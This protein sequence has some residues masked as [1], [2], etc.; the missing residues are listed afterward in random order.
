MGI[1][2]ALAVVTAAMTAVTAL[3]AIPVTA[4]QATTYNGKIAFTSDRSG[5][6]EIWLMDADGGNPDQLTDVAGGN[7]EAA[8]SPDGSKIA[9]ISRRASTPSE[10]YV[11]HADG[12]GQTRLTFS[13]VFR[14][15]HEPTWS[16]DGTQIAFQ[17]GTTLFVINADGTGERRVNST[18]PGSLESPSWSPDGNTLV[19]SGL[20]PSPE[21]EF[22]LFLVD[23][24]SGDIT[25]LTTGRDSNP[26]WSPDGSLISFN[27]SPLGLAPDIYTVKPDGTE[28]TNVTGTDTNESQAGWS[29]DGAKFV[30]HS[31]PLINNLDIYTVNADGTN[32]QRV[33]TDPANDVR[34]AWQPL[35]DSAGP[36]IQCGAADG[37]WHASDVSITCSASDAGSG[38]ADPTQGSFTLSTS[39]DVNTEDGNASTGSLS[40]C[41]NVGNCTTAGPVSGNEVDKRAPGISVSSPA[42]Q[43]YSLNQVVTATYSCSDGG[44]DLASCAGPVA[45]GAAVST[46]TVGTQ[47]FTVN[48][49]DNVGNRGTSTV[50]YTVAYAVALGY[51]PAKPTKRVTVRL[52]DAGSA[53]VSTPVVL[54]AVS[55]D[56]G[57]AAG[58]TFSFNRRAAEYTYSL[59]TRGLASGQHTLQFTAGSDPT[60]HSIPF[61]VR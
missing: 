33:T 36:Q 31:D 23:P 15:V 12:T 8:W 26:E 52:R 51:D 18:Y 6:N 21:L 28:T 43:A 7:D 1:G 38:L 16:P 32:Q 24:A 20:S 39:V 17:G 29:P 49:V 27:H 44:S 54:S 14:N 53:V 55:I 59:P 34:P 45:P 60:I 4:A 56:G 48:A 10:L 3:V 2:R 13:D 50:T 30:F 41:D 11:M 37:A 5:R 61:L 35:D 47:Q 25:R 46:V 22:G 58:G 40:V 9:F 57:T 19:A 42:S